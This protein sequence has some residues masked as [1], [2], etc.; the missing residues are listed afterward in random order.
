[1]NSEP[2]SL[3]RPDEGH[4][5]ELAHPMAYRGGANGRNDRRHLFVGRHGI[6]A[7]EAARDRRRHI[8]GH[9]L[10]VAAMARRPSPKQNRRSTSRTSITP[11]S[12]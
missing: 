3:S 8:L 1:M 12:R 6:A 7:T 9:R 2:L 4:R 5:Q 10:A 11:S